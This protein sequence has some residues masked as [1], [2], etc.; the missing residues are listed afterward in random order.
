[1]VERTAGVNQSGGKLTEAWTAGV[2]DWKI[3][4]SWERM[5]VQQRPPEWNPN[6]GRLGL[7]CFIF[8]SSNFMSMS[9]TVET[10]FQSNG[11]LA[12]LHYNVL[13]LSWPQLPCKSRTNHDSI[14]LFVYLPNMHIILFFVP[15]ARWCFSLTV[16]GSSY[17]VFAIFSVL[18]M[19]LQLLCASFLFIYLFIYKT[20]WYFVTALLLG[21]SL[22]RDWKR[23]HGITLYVVRYF[24]C[25]AFFVV[26][27][28][29]SSHTL[30]QNSFLAKQQKGDSQLVSPFFPP[31][32]DSI[33]V[34]NQLKHK[35]LKTRRQNDISQRCLTF[36]TNMFQVW[37]FESQ[38]SVGSGSVFIR[39]RQQQKN[40]QLGTPNK[41]RSKWPRRPTTI[42]NKKNGVRIT[43]LALSDEIVLSKILKKEIFA[44]SEEERKRGGV[45]AVLRWSWRERHY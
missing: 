5:C 43:S 44:G 14:C 23:H 32:F 33:L 40:L 17:T 35:K 28:V 41:S 8:P 6:A 9:L 1:M 29:L 45:A 11:T 7:H 30:S 27:V 22:P 26:V 31:L 34:F 25:W 36:W 20:L 42:S 21:F 4:S 12:F 3:A 38:A 16:H 24:V 39:G 13:C 37:I 10:F 15:G 19:F 2:I 18:F